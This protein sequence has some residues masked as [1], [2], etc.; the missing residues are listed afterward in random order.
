MMYRVA[1]LGMALLLLILPQVQAAENNVIAVASDGKTMDAAVSQRAARC[2]YF[3][4]FDKEGNL[5]GVE[6][7]PYRENRGSAGVSAADFL[8]ERNVA[9]VVAGMVGNKMEA[10][11]EAHD[12]AFVAYTGIVADAVKHVIK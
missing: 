3:L 11:L 2:S 12:I 8:A 1:I 6:E 7:N 9:V 10:A 4:F 5:K